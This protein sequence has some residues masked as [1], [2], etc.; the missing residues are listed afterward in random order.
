M[1]PLRILL[2]EDSPPNQRLAVGVL[3]K[4]GHEITV[5]NNGREALATLEN[6]S[7]QFDLVLMDVQMP[8]MDGFQATSLIREREARSGTHLPIIAMTA[9]A[10]KGDREECLAAGMDG[11][12]AK[13]IRRRELQ[14][15][16]DEVLG[17]Q[18]A[19]PPDQPKGP[20]PRPILD[21]INWE[22]AEQTTE[23]DPELLRQILAAVIETSPLL[24]SQMEEALRRGESRELR[25]AAHTLKGSLEILGSTRTSELAQR[26]EER[27][28]SGQSEGTRELFES[29]AA[30][31]N[32]LIA[33]LRSR[34]ELLARS[35]QKDEG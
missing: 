10:M 25:R 21:A 13:P 32:V 17:Q 11:Y 24:L 33:E 22:H 35:R 2:A 23:G 1:R 20:A 12:V 7:D 4:W 6:N 28:K 27:A 8:E 16:I 34:D 30:D 5:V 14:Q 3:T 29:L 19:G 31:M 15:V 9:H 18:A 26:L